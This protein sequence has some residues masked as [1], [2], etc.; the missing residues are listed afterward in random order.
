MCCVSLCHVFNL[1]KKTINAV[2]THGLSGFTCTHSQTMNSKFYIP[3]SAKPCVVLKF[4]IYGLTELGQVHT[5]NS[6]TECVNL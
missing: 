1:N 5:D 3:H 2:N 6:L 4:L